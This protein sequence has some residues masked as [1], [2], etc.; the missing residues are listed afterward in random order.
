MENTL[1]NLFGDQTD[2]SSPPRSADSV[3]IDAIHLGKTQ[4]REVAV[5]VEVEMVAVELVVQGTEQVEHT[6]VSETEWV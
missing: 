5:L 2:S 4:H 6:A 1:Q 3:T